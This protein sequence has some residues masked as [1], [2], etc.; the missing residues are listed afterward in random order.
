VETDRP[1][2]TY[3]IHEAEAFAQRYAGRSGTTV[4][5]L[6]EHGRIPLPCDCGDAI[7][8]GWQMAH[9]DEGR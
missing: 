2:I 5:F 8:E 9:T 6:R 7:C 3:D 4:E 1:C